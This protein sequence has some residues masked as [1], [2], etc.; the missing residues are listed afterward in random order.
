LDTD[1]TGNNC[2]DLVMY[3]KI[4]SVVVIV[5]KKSDETLK[6]E[7]IKIFGDQKRLTLRSIVGAFNTRDKYGRRRP[8]RVFVSPGKVTTILRYNPDIFEL[9]E[10]ADGNKK[11]YGLKNDE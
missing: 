8:G 2:F 3:D 5:K 9:K 11:V 6:K 7:I 4:S 10:Y 1:Y